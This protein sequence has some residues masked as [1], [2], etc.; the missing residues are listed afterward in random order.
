[1]A[2]SPSTITTASLIEILA[3][4]VEVRS[5][6]VCHLDISSP[7]YLDNGAFGVV[8]HIW[9]VSTGEERA[10]KEPS[11]RAVRERRV[12][13]DAWRNEARIMGLISHHVR[14]LVFLLSNNKPDELKEFLTSMVATELQRRSPAHDCY[15][16][17]RYLP[18]TVEDGCR[19]PTATCY[20]QENRRGLIQDQAADTGHDNPQASTLQPA[21]QDADQ[22][23]GAS[24]AA[25][26][27]GSVRTR[28]FVRSGTP[29]PDSTC[30]K[31]IVL[32]YY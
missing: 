14:G 25:D 8:W 4:R 20:A 27:L 11:A 17:V 21:H 19:T 2:P 7:L 16:Q 12:D 28:I 26:L 29:P 22:R 24:L 5:L 3:R 1:M 15:D 10:L 13:V 18:D 31:P 30:A 9:D 23:P 32:F 6:V